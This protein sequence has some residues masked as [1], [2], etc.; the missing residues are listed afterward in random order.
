MNVDLLATRTYHSPS[1]PSA[2]SPPPEAQNTMN[3]EDLDFEVPSYQ[4]ALL[5]CLI[6]SWLRESMVLREK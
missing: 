5:L 3:I 6:H 4:A 1:S 2:R